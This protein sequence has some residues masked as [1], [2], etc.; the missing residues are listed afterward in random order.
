[1]LHSCLASPKPR[2]TLLKVVSRAESA[3]LARSDVGQGCKHPQLHCLH[4]STRAIAS[5]LNIFT[6]LERVN[7]P[8]CHLAIDTTAFDPSEARHPFN[9]THTITT[10]LPDSKDAVQ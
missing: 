10:H 6:R 2:D 8:T 1:M 7:L 4:T 3:Q 5:I 9:Y